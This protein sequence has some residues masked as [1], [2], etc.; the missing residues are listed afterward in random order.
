MDDLLVAAGDVVD[1]YF[2]VPRRTLSFEITNGVGVP[3]RFIPSTERPDAVT[4][5]T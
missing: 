1:L 5:R 2:G 4:D 3:L